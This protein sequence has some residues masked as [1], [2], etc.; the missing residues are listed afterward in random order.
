MN[1]LQLRPSTDHCWSRHRG[2]GGS[3]AGARPGR[4]ASAGR[5]RRSNRR[6]SV[7]DQVTTS[8]RT[9]LCK[10][11]TFIINVNVNLKNTDYNLCQ[12]TRNPTVPMDVNA[13]MKQHFIEWYSETFIDF[14]LTCASTHC[15]MCVF[16]VIKG[17]TYLLMITESRESCIQCIVIIEQQIVF[18]FPRK[19]DWICGLVDLDHA[20]IMMCRK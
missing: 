13:V 4:R 1:G 19:S 12:R 18:C 10:L 5:W 7:V 20:I 2:T 15:S 16:H 8:R 14:S 17:F 9:R 3:G 6:R 11:K